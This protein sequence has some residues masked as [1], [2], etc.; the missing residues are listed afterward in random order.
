M[1]KKYDSLFNLNATLTKELFDNVDYPWEVLPNIKDY[2]L[3]IGPTLGEDFNK[4]G[5]DIW[6]HQSV[7]VASTALI[8]GPC[9]IGEGTE[10]RQCAFIRGSAIIGV[11]CTIGNSTEVKNSIIFDGS[12]C[13]HFNYIGD[14]IL[15]EHAHM[16]AGVILSNIKSDRTNVIIDEDGEKYV[17]GLRKISGLIGDYVEIGCNSVICPGTIIYPHTTIYPLTRVRGVIKAN[18]IVKSMDNII[19]KENR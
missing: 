7:K 1:L 16:G 15:G 14:A 17:T 8:N 18:K 4:I 9:I 13:P 12:E 3:K 11:N 5:E 2:I 10:I 6:I 19:D